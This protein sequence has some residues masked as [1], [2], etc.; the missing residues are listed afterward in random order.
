MKRLCILA[1]VVTSITLSAAN[2]QQTPRK[3]RS[4]DTVRAN[5]YA[6]NS[7]KLYING[8]LIAVD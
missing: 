6:D 3:P 7:F 2:A 5:V 4:A 8:E 1:T